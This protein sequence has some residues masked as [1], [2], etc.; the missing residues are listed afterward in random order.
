MRWIHSS[1]DA[2]LAR[3][4]ARQKGLSEISARLLA[5]RNLATIEQV[6]AFLDPGLSKLGDPLELGGMPAAVARV[7]SALKRQESVL[8]F[9]DYDVDGVTSTVL[10]THFLRRFGL[11]PKFVVP[12]RLE[13][14][15]GL[16]LDSLTR[17]LEEGKPD[18]LIAV[19]C[20]T[21]SSHE[22]AWLREQ[23]ISVIILDHH[24][25]KESLPDD[26][27]MVNPHVHD[28]EEVPWKNLCSVG[29]V[30]K[31]CHAFLKVMRE[32]G[33]ALAS[34][35][36]LREYLDLVALG[37]VADLVDL[38]GEN[39]ILVRNGLRRLEK[40]QR[41]GICALMEVAGLTLG[42]TL[43]PSDIGFRLGPRINASG[44]LDDATLPI[45]LLLS[46]N[47]QSCRDSAM[48][49]DQFNRDRQEIERSIAEMAEEQVSRLYKDHMGIVVHAP[50][51]HPGV[52]G[53][54]ASR[55]AR[56]FHRP[57]LVLGSEGEGLAKGSGR[58]VEGV[59][60]VEVLKE[61]TDSIAQWGGHPMAV[62]LTVEEENIGNL[63][64]VF[65][66]ALRVKYG[67]GIP[68]KVIT[69]EAEVRPEELTDTL[70]S[71]LEQLAPYG[72]G[73][74]E[75]VFAVTGVVLPGLSRVGKT[76]LKFGVPRPGLSG[77]VECIAWN[78]ADKP[79]ALGKPI[80][81]AVR[82]GWH[83]WRGERFPRL[84]L[85]DWRESR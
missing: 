82:V 77:P 36:D 74:P 32:K 41:P 16:S 83:T 22:V 64:D 45:Q 39:R 69:L 73:N 80:D 63:R 25:S 70:L 4:I 67:E 79:P 78:A 26:C 42:G 1:V 54:V 57:A 60:L 28:P 24:T 46:D 19:D 72:Q 13:E 30:F 27:I 17:A 14:G 10:L 5:G 43:S 50:D 18:L 53:I 33:D 48:T 76:H 21:S 2:H 3:S 23:G 85:L 40:C 58:S 37:T 38:T 84:T 20:G 68:E 59:D 35:T 75:P 51:W 61:C 12:K 52:V 6:D 55:L 71:E 56:K 9:G 8:L 81:L 44:R 31:F 7:E 15:Y 62:G 47:W 11:S 66:T 34:S 29:L 49:L 65:N